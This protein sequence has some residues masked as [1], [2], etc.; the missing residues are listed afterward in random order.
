LRCARVARGSP[1]EPNAAAVDVPSG[2][3]RTQFHDTHGE[4]FGGGMFRPTAFFTFAG[5]ARPTLGAADPISSNL[6]SV[7]Q[8]AVLAPVGTV[9]IVFRT[10]EAIW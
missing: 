6:A 9:E 10:C 3:D 5:A 1:E 4:R 7:A 8:A 2:G